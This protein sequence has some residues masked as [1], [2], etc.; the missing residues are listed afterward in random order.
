MK[1]GVDRIPPKRQVQNKGG[2]RGG[3]IPEERIAVIFFVDL[4]GSSL[5]SSEKDSSS[6][7]NDY[8]RDYYQ[9][10]EN[11]LEHYCREANLKYVHRKNSDQIFSSTVRYKGDEIVGFIHFSKSAPREDVAAATVEVI[12][13]IYALKIFWLGSGYNLNRIRQGQVPREISS[14]I[15]IGPIQLVRN[16][17]FEDSHFEVGYAINLA[18][19]VEGASRA[20]DSSHVLV[21]S[22]VRAACLEWVKRGTDEGTFFMR[23]IDFKH[24]TGASLAD[25]FQGI[26][27]KPEAWEL[28]PSNHGASVMRR[29]ARESDWEVTRHLQNGVGEPLLTKSNPWLLPNDTR[30]TKEDFKAILRRCSSTTNLWN[31]INCA[32]LVSACRSLGS[33]SDV[34]DLLNGCATRIAEASPS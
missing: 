11:A 24:L 31:Q 30:M 20:G 1:E 10:I 15:H 3:V 16:S 6:F 29:L 23:G 21:T 34:K 2:L 8:V 14:G 17:A 13:F 22:E 33:A 26:D 32:L 7:W 4:V 9:A 19:R 5:V 12:R 27:P 18:K 25:R 28:V